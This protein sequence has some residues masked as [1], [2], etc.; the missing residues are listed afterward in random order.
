[1]SHIHLGNITKTCNNI[2]KLNKIMFFC[3]VRGGAKLRKYTRIR[4]VRCS[5]QARC[6]RLVSSMDHRFLERVSHR[7]TQPLATFG[8]QI[9]PFCPMSRYVH[10]CPWSR[11][12]Q[13]GL[14][15]RHQK[16]RRLV[17]RCYRMLQDVTGCYR[18]Q[19]QDDKAH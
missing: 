1:M 8:H 12:S 2:A 7:F 9:C 19:D 17:K 4:L 6:R 13:R 14:P 16:A 11:V 15:M 5:A 18:Q 10:D 3:P